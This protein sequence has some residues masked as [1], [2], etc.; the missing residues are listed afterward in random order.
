MIRET[1][2]LGHDNTLDWRLTETGDAIDMSSVTSVELIVNGITFNSDS[3]GGNTSTG[4]FYWTTG[5]PADGAA[6]LFLR[7]GP[8]FETAE[9]PAGTYRSCRLILY[10]VININGLLWD[11]TISFVV[12]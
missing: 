12:K 4:P 1:V 8:L 7:L 2:Y 6:N 3:Y 11:N 10:D 5:I 9:I